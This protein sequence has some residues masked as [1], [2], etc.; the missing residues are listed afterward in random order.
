MLHSFAVEKNENVMRNIRNLLLVALA[1]QVQGACDPGGISD[2][3]GG[4]GQGEMVMGHGMMIL[5]KKL[6]DPYSVINIT[7]ALESLY[8]TKAG[9]IEVS[10]TDLYVR[11]LPGS[12]EE[13]DYLESLGV[14]MLDHPVDYEI[15]VD[16]DYYHDPEIPEEEITWQ[17]AVLSPDFDFPPG[18]RYEILDRCHITEHDVFTRA[19]GDGIDWDA[20]EK[21]SFRLTGNASMLEDGGMAKSGAASPEGRITLVD[22]RYPDSPAGVKGVRVAC[23]VFVKIGQAYT[24]SEGWYRIDK[25]FS[26]KPRY[27]LVFKNSKG[28]G[29]GLNLILVGGSMSTMGRQSQEGYSLEVGK[30]SDKSLFAR[31]V[32]NNTTWDYMEMC[33]SSSGVM[34]A[35]PAN[36]RLWIL[37]RFDAS[38]TV[39]MQHGAGIDN[40]KIKEF[41]GEWATLVKWFLPDITLG[42]KGDED[43]ASIYSTTIHE[44]AHASHFQQ[45]ET[46]WWDKLIEYIMTSYISSGLMAYGTGGERYAGYCEV[47]EMWAYYFS[48][49][50]YRTRYPSSNAM[51]GTSWWF[52]PQVLYYLDDLGLDHYKIFKALVATVI[53]RDSLQEK[54]LALY[55]E[56]KTNIMLAFNRYL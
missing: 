4:Y 16:G 40:T 34:M 1:L 55:P 31:C 37:N 54:L 20:V 18:I 19:G 53:D 10:A 46:E 9:E 11:F 21:E 7:K 15:L 2:G 38:S 41:L 32:V 6:E 33:K 43:Y 8:P 17:Y 45:V 23:N 44:L 5:G 36:L 29:I 26:S 48:S 22:D 35:P 51:F 12:Q 42:L 49:K 25:S 27:F 30:D 47:A 52:Y 13:L 56:F 14:E 28:F 24:D 50:M 3:A 39:M